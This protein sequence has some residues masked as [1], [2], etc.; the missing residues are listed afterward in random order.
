MVAVVVVVE[1]EEI[2]AGKRFQLISVK[3][4]RD[5]LSSSPWPDSCAGDVCVSCMG[6][7]GHVNRNMRG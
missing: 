5:T 7:E 1:G 6:T 3:P 2:T 4:I